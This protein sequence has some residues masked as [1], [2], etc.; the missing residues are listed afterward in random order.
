MSRMARP[1]QVHG[2]PQPGSADREAL[3]EAG[4]VFVATVAFPRLTHRLRWPTRLGPRGLLIYIMFNTAA[5]MAIRTWLTPALGR[6]HERRE[7]L[8]RELRTQLGREPSEEEVNLRFW[9]TL[10]FRP[11]G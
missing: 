7:D 1:R 8:R 2:V 5:G 6:L 11:E 10:G 4:W 3:R 9:A